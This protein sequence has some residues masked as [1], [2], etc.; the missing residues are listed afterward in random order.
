ML[1]HN[2]DVMDIESKS[3]SQSTKRGSGAAAA[4]SRRLTRSGAKELGL[5]VQWPQLGGS[6]GKKRRRAVEEDPKALASLS[7]KK[8]L[9]QQQQQHEG[10]KMLSAASVIGRPMYR[11][12]KIDKRY[13]LVR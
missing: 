4:A 11:R 8:D 2:V 7:V 3:G 5:E 9:E 10:T 1:V 12:S 13:G 6:K